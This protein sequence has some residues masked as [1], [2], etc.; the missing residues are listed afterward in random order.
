MVQACDGPPAGYRP[1]QP[2]LPNW[3]DR[4]AEPSVGSVASN[5][6]GRSRC[7]SGCNGLVKI[8]KNVAGARPQ[9]IIS[10]LFRHSLHDDH[11]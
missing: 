6:L 11:R 9:W 1:R 8:R 7:P 5:A 2:P 4:K 3:N 10:V